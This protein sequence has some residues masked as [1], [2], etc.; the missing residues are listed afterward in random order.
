MKITNE[1]LEGYLNCKTKGHLELGGESGVMSDYEAMT[2]EARQASR[3][4]AVAKLVV[5]FG[6]GD[7]C[8]GVAVTAAT[9]K[10]GAPLLPDATL[11]SDVL[12]LRFDALKRAEG[13]S[14][15]GDH[16]YLPV[17]HKYA[18]K[19][20]RQQK[21]LLTVLGLGLARVQGLRPAVGLIARGSESQLGKVRL[22]EKLYRQGQLILSE[23]ERLQAGGDLPRLTLNDHC[24]V[25][26]FKQRCHEQAVRE[27]SLSLLRGIG[28][29]EIKNLGRKGI[30]TLTQLAHTFR[31]KRKGKRKERKAGRHF[32]ALK[33][34][35]IRDKKIYVL[36][37]PQLPESPV[38]AYFDIEGV[39]DEGLVYLIGLK[40]VTN[41]AE[42]RFSFWADAKE[43]E[44]GI[45]ERMLD[46]LSRHGNF[47]LFCYGSYEKAFLARMG[48]QTARR[49]LAE[50]ALKSLV[51][52]LSVVHAHIYFPCFS[53]GLKD[54]AG[55]LGHCWADKGASGI[56]SLVWR[57][58]WEA[59]RESV[60]KQKL[61][62]YNLDDCGALRRV[63]DLIRGVVA[64]MSHTAEKTTSGP[65]LPP[66]GFV[67]DLDKL[68]QSHKWG[69]VNYVHPD[70]E[71]INDCAYF[72]YQR[73]RVFVRTNK[74]LRKRKAKQGDN[75]SRNRRFRVAQRVSILSQECPFCKGKKLVLV[76][77]REQV[78]CRR[79]RSRKVFDLVITP[80]GMRRRV[81]EYSSDV[82]RCL[83]CNKDFV[84]EQ[85]E[86]M[87]SHSHG[88]KSWAMYQHVAHRLS[89][90]TLQ[91]MFEE[92]FGLRIGRT[93][94]HQFKSLMARYYR[95][96]Y[97]GLLDK[98]LAGGLLHIDET[99]VQLKTGKAYV[100]V[101]TS[102]ED[103]VFMLRP[104]REGD[105]LKELLK[106]F[107]GVLVSDFYAAYDSIECPQQKC[108]I[109]LIRD[110]NQELLNNPFDEELKSITRPFGALLRTIVTTVDQHGLKRQYLER[111]KREVDAFFCHLR[112]QTLRS[113]AAESLR[114]RLEKYRDKLFTFI[115][116]D[117]VPWNNTNAEHA[118]KQFA[119]YREDTVGLMKEFG[120]N[121]YLVLLS[122]CHACRYK[123]VS[124][125]KFLLSKE[126]DVDVYCEGKRQKRQ[127]SSIEA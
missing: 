120:L 57:A 77:R 115:G 96:T 97:Q 53:N 81:V 106:G 3:E 1:I 56:Q 126:L 19:V 52:V 87:D 80:S 89:L 88:L 118:I 31:P 76:P 64:R 33:A 35:A 86:Q 69:K 27:D 113:E 42:E 28:E 100:W 55:H 119:Y 124:F 20:G 41:S 5:R 10:K 107:K 75:R 98:I 34:L 54:V 17:L 59:T 8:R 72:D 16:H 40:V 51:N 29:K 123:G 94:I 63:V 26:E 73:E 95:G 6:E 44:A 99:E 78:K 111:H 101:F 112:G 67:A 49:E 22:D 48:K 74:I 125:L 47:V 30:L 12:S 121:H 66:L 90:G 11:D 114:T 46:V 102:L 110:I 50:R 13:A 103:V 14:K 92:F 68:A 70:Y 4:E 116:H 84:P 39:P 9:L 45:Y 23:L 7:A 108:L 117:G 15:V 37:S 58:R 71:F 109:H 127:A 62:A 82:H 36:G 38:Q 79:L 93:D 83:S 61:V 24:Q 43:H 21:L 25:C 32:H 91:T 105:F 2:T 18:D 85:H 65:D 104:S 60:W 122:I